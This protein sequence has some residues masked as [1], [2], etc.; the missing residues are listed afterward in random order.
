MAAH[1][2]NF[3][4]MAEAEEKGHVDFVNALKAKGKRNSIKHEDVSFL[5]FPTHKNTYNII[6][7]KRF[8]YH[9]L[10]H[11]K[12]LHYHNKK[13]PVQ[14]RIQEETVVLVF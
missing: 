5:I 12:R 6:L 7:I 13:N 4:N 3:G 10:H 11:R 8:L 9:L 14:N 1:R 2:N